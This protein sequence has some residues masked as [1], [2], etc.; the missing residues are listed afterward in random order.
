MSKILER[1]RERIILFA[2]QGSRGTN[3]C[4]SL[5]KKLMLTSIPSFNLNNIIQDNENIY[6]HQGFN[7]ETIIF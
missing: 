6:A 3:R 4:K 1:N 5:D 7:I 2:H